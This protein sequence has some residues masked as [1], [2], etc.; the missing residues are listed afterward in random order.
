MLLDKISVEGTVEII[1]LKMNPLEIK[2]PE[3]NESSCPF[4][5]FSLKKFFSFEEKNNSEE[6][7]RVEDTPKC[8]IYTA[9][10]LQEIFKPKGFDN[11]HDKYGVDIKK[12]KENYRE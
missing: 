10:N 7:P 1:P 11:L 3:I 2:T 5:G 8:I 9:R 12:M 4:K 6:I